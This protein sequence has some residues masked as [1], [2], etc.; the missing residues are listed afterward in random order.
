M[1]LVVRVLIKVFYLLLV[2]RNR[3]HL[4]FFILIGMGLV[5]LNHHEAV[6]FV[7]SDFAWGKKDF[8]EKVLFF[9]DFLVIGLLKN[10]IA[11]LMHYSFNDTCL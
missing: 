3:Q 11:V 8:G 2:N 9:K 4:F 6:V 5:P 10:L 7:K 1:L